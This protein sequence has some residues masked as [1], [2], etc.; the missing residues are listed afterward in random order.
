[1]RAWSGLVAALAVLIAGGAGAATVRTLTAG[2][3]AARS[4]LIFIGTVTAQRS[5]LETQPVRVWTDTTFRVEQVVKGDKL[6]HEWRLTQLGGVVGEGAD[7]IG[8]D[9]PGYARFAVGERVFLFL[10]RTSTGRLVPTGLAQGKYVLIDDAK[11]G[12][13]MAAR[14]LR[15]LHLLGAMPDKRV[16]GMPRDWNQLP[17]A[18]LLAIAR[19]E[20][21]GPTPLHVV[22]RPAP[23]VEDV[24]TPQVVL[25]GAEGAR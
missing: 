2:E 22:R 25:P 23:P 21:P 15:G 18:D 7:R 12:V 16:A 24:Q 20:R 4:E 9:V 1:M 8:Q 14:D 5:R 3:L 13:T 6:D 17:L 11:S 10:E 19:G